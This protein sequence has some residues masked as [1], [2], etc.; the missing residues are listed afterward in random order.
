LRSSASSA[1]PTYLS[2]IIAG[3]KANGRYRPDGRLG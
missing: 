2:D 1:A 3:F